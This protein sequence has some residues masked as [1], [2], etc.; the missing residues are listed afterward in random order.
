[1]SACLLGQPVRYDGG[2]KRDDFVAGVLP[3]RVRLIPVCPEV[4]L[5]LGTPRETLRLIGAHGVVRLVMANGEDYTTAMRDYAA[6]RVEALA[7]DAL[8]GY[9]FK[10]RSPSCGVD[11]VAVFGDD[12]L[13]IPNGRG[14]FAAA[15]I[16]RFP[17]LP[18]VEE[19]QLRD[20]PA[21]TTFLE[22]VF[23]HWRS[24]SR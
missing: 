15:L 1:V 19:G 3:T 2:H 23:T 4:E 21:Q 17:D 7:A 18:V 11:S 10:A 9:I 5:G 22:R 24:R 6:A 16:A 20:N 12:G 13:P 14:L 8:N